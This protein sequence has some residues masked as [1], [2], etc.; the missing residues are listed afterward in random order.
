M[1]KGTATRRGSPLRRRRGPPLARADAQARGSH[2]RLPRS[3]AAG[4]PRGRRAR[5]SRATS[6]RGTD[7]CI[8]RGC[9]VAVLRLDAATRA[10]VPSQGHSARGRIHDCGTRVSLARRHTTTARA[11]KQ[12]IYKYK[13]SLLP[14]GSCARLGARCRYFRYG[15]RSTLRARAAR[16][17]ASTTTS[18]TTSRVE[19]PSEILFRD[20][21]G[22]EQVCV[23]YSV[24]SVHICIRICIC[25]FAT[26]IC[27][28]PR[29]QFL[30]RFGL[31]PRRCTYANEMRKPSDCRESYVL[32]IWQVASGGG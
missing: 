31:R 30:R 13:Y 7:S 4:P 22:C 3:S 12:P 15:I 19:A 18:T 16:A 26:P 10:T 5:A 6:A 11:Q 23:A 8:G 21:A 25:T 17:R 24:H 1:T 2:S 14:R 9:G 32:R 27:V 29:R 20:P 28:A